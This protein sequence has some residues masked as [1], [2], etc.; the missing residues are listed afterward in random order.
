MNRLLKWGVLLFVLFN[1]VL[2]AWSVLHKDIYYYTDIGRDFLIFDEIAAKKFVLV[3]PRADAQGLFH[4]IAWHYFN[5][6]AYLLGNGNPVILGWFWIILATG[7]IAGSYFIIKKLFDKQSAIIATLLISSYIVPYMQGLFHGKG[8]WFVLP[9]FF[10]FFIRY[11]QTKKPW[12]LIAHL[13]MLGLLVQ[14]E[15]ALGLPFVI[16][17]V[18]AVTYLIVKNKSFGH[19]LLFGILIIPFSSFLLFDLKHNFLQ[20]KSFLAYGKGTRDGLPTPFNISFIDRLTHVA[21]SGIGILQ[22]SILKLNVIFLAF[23]YAFYKIIRGN[24]EHKKIY[25][26]FLYFYIGYY[27]LTLLHGGL[28]IE[29][30]YLPLALLPILIFSTFHRYIPKWIYYGL[31]TVIL[32]ISTSQNISYIKKVTQEIGKKTTSWQFHLNMATKVFNDAPE[33]FGYFIFAPDIYGYQDKYA[34]SYAERLYNKKAFKFEKKQTTY[35]LME[36]IPKSA[37]F[38]DAAWWIKEKLKIKGEPVKTIQLGLGYKIQKYELTKEEL[39]A[40]SEITP[41][42]W[43][44]F[45]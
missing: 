38:L 31:I 17:S 29:F 35:V 20:L 28:L 41:S 32:A 22:L 27:V 18:I 14:F 12:H 4:G 7:L 36:P 44:Y 40:P 43:L 11:M 45:R 6:P 2:S 10:F 8:V 16:L 9:A 3:G 37:F 13:L 24:D 39:Q 34:M 25:L 19:F 15:I 21:F 5:M 30:W 26:A 33:E 42:D 1:L 23:I